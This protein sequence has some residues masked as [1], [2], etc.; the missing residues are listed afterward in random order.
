MPAISWLEHAATT[1]WAVSAVAAVAM[2]DEQLGERVCLYVVAA[3]QVVDLD[4]VRTGM[5]ARGVARFK[6]P[7][8]W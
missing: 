6:W 8:D 1:N 3:G 5:D 2:P 7:R 4:A